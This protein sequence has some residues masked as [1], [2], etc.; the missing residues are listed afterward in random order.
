MN[1]TARRS[2]QPRTRRDI[3]TWR[4]LLV[5]NVAA[6]IAALVLLSGCSTIGKVLE[7]ERDRVIVEVAK[8]VVK[9]VVKEQIGDYIDKK[10]DKWV[11]YLLGLLGIGGTTASGVLGRWHGKRTEQKRNGNGNGKKEYDG[12]GKQSVG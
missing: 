1:S 9:D 10:V 4:L 5:G 11:P 7:N 6:G 3:S 8:D 12:Q 2:D